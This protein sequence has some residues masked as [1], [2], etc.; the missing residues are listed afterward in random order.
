MFVGYPILDKYFWYPDF[1]SS[2]FIAQLMNVVYF[3]LCLLV[4]TL[5]NKINLQNPKN[6]I[7][8]QNVYLI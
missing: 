6:K 3:L 5:T 1:Y 8:H 7:N 2:P 4:T